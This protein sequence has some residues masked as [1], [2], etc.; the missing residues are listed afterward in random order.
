MRD[1]PQHSDEPFPAA[2]DAALR[3]RRGNAYGRFVRRPFEREV[4]EAIGV[5]VHT[6]TGYSKGART[7][8]PDAMAACARLLE[9]PAGGAYFR[10]Y[11][12][13]QVSQVL[14]AHPGAMADFYAG[15][16]QVAKD[17]DGRVPEA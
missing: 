12:L 7:P 8:Q 10:E 9:L 16:M 4:A 11:R 6:I 3:A 17:E 1:L 14:S 5:S 13:W 15:I 2:L